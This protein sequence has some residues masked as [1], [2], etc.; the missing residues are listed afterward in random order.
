MITTCR[1]CTPSA[2]AA[3]RPTRSTNVR[4]S[5]C[6]H[7]S[8]SSTDTARRRPATWGSVTA[9]GAPARHLRPAR[10]GTVAL[11]GPH[12]VPG[13]PASKRSA[14]RRAPGRIPLGYF[15]DA[16]ATRRTFPVVEGQRVVMSGDRASAREPTA[17]CGCSAATRS[18]STPVARRC[19]SKRSRR[20]CGPS[21][22]SPTRWWSGG[23][24]S[25]GAKKSSRS[26]QLRD[27]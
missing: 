19:S 14:G 8:P 5:N 2:P 3:P 23:R 15:D 22:G 27:G 9:A 20:C 7:S 26:S 11:R 13:N 4:C 21:P 1:R 6:C 12:P 24:A 25:A 18:W 16:D 10:G 17:P